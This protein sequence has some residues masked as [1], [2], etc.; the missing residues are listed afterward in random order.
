MSIVYHDGSI[1]KISKICQ[2]SLIEALILAN[3][4]HPHIVSI[5]KIK[6]KK[7]LKITMERGLITLG[8]LCRM[9]E[10][11]HVSIND[12]INQIASGLITLKN[13]GW[14]HGDIKPENIV[15][16]SV[17]PI[18]VKLIDFNM[19]RSINLNKETGTIYYR[20]IESLKH[21][22][23]YKTNHYFD[24]NYGYHLY[25]SW[26][27]GLT[28]VCIIC[29]YSDFSQF[30]EDTETIIEIVDQW[31]EIYDKGIQLLPYILCK[32][33]K[34]PQNFLLLKKI[35]QYLLHPDQSLR[36]IDYQKLLSI[37]DI[38]PIQTDFFEKKNTLDTNDDLILSFVAYSTRLGLS[39]YAV[40][41]GINTIINYR[42][43]LHK[44]LNCGTE[45]LLLAAIYFIIIDQINIYKVPSY[46]SND[47]S[48][49]LKGIYFVKCILKYISKIEVPIT[50]PKNTKYVSYF[51]NQ[52]ER[53]R[54]VKRLQLK[55]PKLIYHTLG[56]YCT[57][58][59]PLSDI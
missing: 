23:K 30:F 34:N 59:Y 50:H 58:F 26:A 6:I 38:S 17:S 27:F 45:G 33:T 20:P 51:F 8:I 54:N 29:N 7:D 47:L 24:Y 10:I 1:T 48:V 5:E 15:V 28:C 4:E 44:Y 18:H 21:Y 37:I 12:I 42:H 57:I 9:F 16:T 25:D 14:Y 53:F 43:K 39:T 3:I 22:V 40:S 46:T 11:N 49:P 19:A 56:K 13:Y 2:E 32:I 35:C 31:I 52:T 55:F 41:V 36:I